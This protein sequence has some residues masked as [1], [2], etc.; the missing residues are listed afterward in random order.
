MRTN[1]AVLAL[2]SLAASCGGRSDLQCSLDSQ[3]DLE[4]GGLCIGPGTGSRWCAY[5]DP[6]CDSGYRYSNIQ[7]GDGVSGQCVA[8]STADGGGID[9][10]AP[11]CAG[12]P[13]TCGPQE[14]ESCCLSLD[15][16]G[17]SFF[18]RYD[19]GASPLGGGQTFPATVSSFRLDK[20]EVT[21]GRFRL[22]LK[23]GLGTKG[24]PPPERAGAHLAI[25][26]SGWDTAWNKHLSDDT[27]SI[28][29]SLSTPSCRYATWTDEAGANEN[30]PIE[31]VNWYEAA[32]FCIWDGGYLPTEAESNYAASGGNEQRAYPWSM[33]AQSTSIDGAHASYSDA[34]TGEDAPN[35]VGDGMAGCAVTDLVPVGTKP[36]GNGKWGHADLAGNVTE[37]V[38]DYY[39]SAATVQVPCN[40]CA[41]VTPSEPAEPGNPNDKSISREAWRGN[42]ISTAAALRN[43]FGV[44]F[45]IPD[46]A[47][48]GIRCAR[49]SR[50]KLA[51]SSSR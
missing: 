19:L 8:S 21:V 42:F 16:P 33:P 5:R 14:N 29:R 22:F 12:L 38:L 45:S 32:A 2:L 11:S 27:K 34:A 44:S 15:V 46:N 31:C 51:T 3:C 30:R 43:F 39:A 1:F 26:G 25:P 23:E 48:S 50:A 49:P 18:R 6:Q 4:A 28:T 36:A 24:K 10:I 40:D 35:C 37:W 20:Y 7:V 47:V 17:G 9:D 13:A 41:N